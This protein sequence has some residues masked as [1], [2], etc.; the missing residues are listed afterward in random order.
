MKRKLCKEL[1]ELLR[2]K[3]IA[4]LTVVSNKL[5]NGKPLTVPGQ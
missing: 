3:S 5:D 2:K 4:R 1:K